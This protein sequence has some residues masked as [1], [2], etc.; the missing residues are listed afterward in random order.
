MVFDIFD[1]FM[2]SLR[3][4]ERRMAR[5]PK[6][7]EGIPFYNGETPN[8]IYFVADIRGSAH[9]HNSLRNLIFGSS[10]MDSS[11]EKRLLEEFYDELPNQQKEISTK[12]NLLQKILSI[13]TIVKDDYEACVS[14]LLKMRKEYV[15]RVKT[16]QA[17]VQ[18]YSH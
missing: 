12:R 18:G 14:T 15:E 3:E 10:A 11:L 9:E 8:I 7:L 6:T 2:P 4:Y 13:F 1:A 17:L 5:I 16:Y